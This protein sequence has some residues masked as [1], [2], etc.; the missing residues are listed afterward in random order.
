M[1]DFWTNF[2]W[3]FIIVHQNTTDKFEMS[4]ESFKCV[5]LWKMLGISTFLRC[6]YAFIDKNY[7]FYFQ[8]IINWWQLT[9]D[10]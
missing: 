6:T 5:Q 9:N 4:L 3:E 2:I 7:I 8:T 1:C 10:F